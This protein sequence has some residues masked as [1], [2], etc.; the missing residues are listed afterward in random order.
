MAEEER[1]ALLGDITASVDRT[2]RR[3]MAETVANPLA[4]L[5]VS[6]ARQMVDPL[7]VPPL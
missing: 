3:G 7:Q 6:T 1:N 4:K 5:V 2:M